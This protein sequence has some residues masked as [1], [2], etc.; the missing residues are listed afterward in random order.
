MSKHTPKPWR[1]A[2]S[3][4][5]APE[6]VDRLA[7]DVQLN[8]GN[9]EDNKANARLIAAAPDL[10]DAALEL[11]RHDESDMRFGD[12]RDAVTKALGHKP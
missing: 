5:R 11:I 12:L 7:L 1:V 8:G 9:R 4:V 10:L 6:T 2:G 3:H